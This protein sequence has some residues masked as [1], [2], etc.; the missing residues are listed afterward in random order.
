MSEEAGDL[1]CV[2]AGVRLRNPLVLASG[3]WGTS[4]DLLERAARSGAGAVTAKTCTLEPRRGHR[5]PSA[6]DWGGGLINAM[7]LPNPGAKEETLLLKQAKRAL[8]PLGVALIASV[9]ADTPEGFAEAATLVAQAEPDLIELNMSC[10]NVKDDCGVI[11]AGSAGATYAATAAAAGATRIPL[12]VK[13]APNVPSVAEIARAAKDA[14]AR[15]LTVI[16]T[17]PG[18]LIDAEACQP[19]LANRSG[20]ISG[21]ALKPIAL[22][23]VYE[24]ADAVDLPIIGTGGVINGTDAVEMLMAGAEA[25]GIGTAIEYRGQDALT[26]ILKELSAWMSAHQVRRLSEIRGKAHEAA[27]RPA[28]TNPPPV[29]GWSHA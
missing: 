25:V 11:F 9:S 22:R 15:G 10:P 18:M 19:V 13:L 17:M 1:S 8:A 6:V 4:P 3:I 14:G 26:Q 2:L 21:P 29:P 12:L 28:P 20:G 24:A 5:N 16:N 27:H 23:C 7:G